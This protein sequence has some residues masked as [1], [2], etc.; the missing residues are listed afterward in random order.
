MAKKKTKA[1]SA[2]ITPPTPIDREA[3][4]L[5]REEMTPALEEAIKINYGWTTE[6]GNIRFSDTELTVTLTLRLPMKPSF[7]KSPLQR[8]EHAKYR[9]AYA[10]HFKRYG[11]KKE[12]LGAKVRVYGKMYEIIGFAKKRKCF[13]ALYDK[14]RA[15]VFRGD[16]TEVSRALQAG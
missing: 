15:K 5:F 13:V 7:S 12:W 10:A 3:C 16:L 6:M 14:N 8:P 2:K 4:K 1:K 11:F 9:A